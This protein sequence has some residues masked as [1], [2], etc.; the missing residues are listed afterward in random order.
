MSEQARLH[1]AAII[2]NTLKILKEAFL[3]FVA[4]IFIGD[5]DDGLS[6]IHI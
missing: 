3:P 6:L 2:L 4:I 1:P 5:A